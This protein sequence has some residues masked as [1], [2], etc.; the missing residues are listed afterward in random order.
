METLYGARQRVPEDFA[1]VLRDLR[2]QPGSGPLLNALLAA[3][4]EPDAGWGAPALAAALGPPATPGSVSK[5]IERGRAA[6]RDD[7][8]LLTALDKYAI[9][10]AETKHVMADGKYLD[11]KDIAEL[12]RMQA[13]ASKVNGALPAGHPDRLLSEALTDELHRLVDQEKISPNYLSKEMGVSHRTITSRLERRGWRRP[14]PSVAGTA[15]GRY[16]NRKIGDPGEG[17]RRLTREQRAELRQL[18]LAYAEPGLLS[19]RAVQTRRDALVGKLRDYVEAGFTLAN[20]AQ[21]MS[22]QE[23]RLRY[24]MLAGLL[25]P[26]GRTPEGSL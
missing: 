7:Q 5:R 19:D 24:S 18:W 25:G 20:L 3:C 11:P 9:P 13:R 26:A 6:I 23:I 17:A 8:D 22:N 12:K 15:S 4:R 2:D 1:R 10:K 14:P 21:T 16:H